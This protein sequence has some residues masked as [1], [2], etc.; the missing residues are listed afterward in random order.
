MLKSAALNNPAVMKPKTAEPVTAP[1]TPRMRNVIKTM[2][3]NVTLDRRSFV[4]GRTNGTAAADEDMGA[5]WYASSSSFEGE[6]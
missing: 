4:F 2:I 1:A 3:A 6:W 5:I